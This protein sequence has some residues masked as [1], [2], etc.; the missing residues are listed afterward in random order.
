M[1]YVR[2]RLTQLGYALVDV[3]DEDGNVVLAILE[4]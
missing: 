4:N 1:D 2:D 3:H